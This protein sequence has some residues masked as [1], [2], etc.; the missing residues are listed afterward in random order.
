MRYN[1]AGCADIHLLKYFEIMCRKV[2]RGMPSIIIL[3]QVFRVPRSNFCLHSPNCHGTHTHTHKH[4]LASSL[5]TSPA[6]T[7]AARK[8]L[9]SGKW[10]NDR[11]LLADDEQETRKYPTETRGWEGEWRGYGV[12]SILPRHRC[13]RAVRLSI[14]FIRNAFAITLRCPGHGLSNGP[15]GPENGLV[16]RCVCSISG[17]QPT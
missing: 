13:H 5:K 7:G 10:Q 17:H 1:L 14:H 8:S 3:P 11:N 16:M 6:T 15:R 2:L 12:I 9:I 4:S